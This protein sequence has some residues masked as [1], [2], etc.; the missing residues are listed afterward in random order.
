MLKNAVRTHHQ[1]HAFIDAA[2][3]AYW[4]NAASS[5]SRITLQLLQLQLPG[6]QQKQVEGAAFYITGGR[7][8]LQQGFCTE[9]QD[10]A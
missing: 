6:Y 1:L 8:P 5:R 9:Q 4:T 3:Q 10:A 7:Q 2:S